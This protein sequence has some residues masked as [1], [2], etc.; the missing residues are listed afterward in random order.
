MSMLPHTDLVRGITVHANFEEVD[1]IAV[2]PAE[3]QA[4]ILIVDDRTDKLLVFKTILEDLG[5]NIVTLQSGEDALRW[6]L[7]N[8]CAVMLLDV[9][10]W[11]GWL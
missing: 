6:L 4:N 5:Q 7:D 2:T 1:D 11:N 3:D 10:M 9:N 8:D